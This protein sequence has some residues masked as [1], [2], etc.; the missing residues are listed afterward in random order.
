MAGGSGGPAPAA[1]TA[2]FAAPPPAASSTFSPPL[3]AG[4]AVA[5]SSED[6]KLFLTLTGLEANP[7]V[8]SILSKPAG[9]KVM[10]DF[11]NA[12]R[13]CRVAGLTVFP[14]IPCTL[15]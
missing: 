5:P 12:A 9:W 3:V 8:T 10:N 7:E 14:T 6:Q 4:Q 15:R 1:G 13:Q 2:P 11:L